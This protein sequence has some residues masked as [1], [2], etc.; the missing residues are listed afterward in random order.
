MYTGDFRVEL[1]YLNMRDVELHQAASQCTDCLLPTTASRFIESILLEIPSN[2]FWLERDNKTNTLKVHDDRKRLG[3]L[4]AFLHNHFALT[5]LESKQFS[6]CEGCTFKQ[7]AGNI[8]RR[9]KEYDFKI[10]IIESAT[11]EALAILLNRIRSPIFG[12]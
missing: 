5:R 6:C 3:I 4:Y 9:I 8:Q 2:L 11:P 1:K 7:L 10:C 12:I